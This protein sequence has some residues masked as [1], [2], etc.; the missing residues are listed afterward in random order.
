M[1][2]CTSSLART[3]SSS[4]IHLA[5]I[6]ILLLVTEVVSSLSLS[7]LS[8][9]V[10]VVDSPRLPTGPSANS[11]QQRLGRGAIGGRAGKQR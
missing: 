7:Q 5:S 1:D 2:M 3:L 8:G 11:L 4:S 6:F 9:S 10:P